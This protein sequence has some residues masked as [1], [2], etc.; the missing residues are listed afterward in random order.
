MRASLQH[1][2]FNESDLMF[3]HAVVLPPPGRDYTT[4][5]RRALDGR[6]E[7]VAASLDSFASRAEPLAQAAGMIVSTLRAGGRV[8][9]AGNGGSAAEAQHFAG[10]LVGRFLMERRPYAAISLTV[11]SSILTAI[12]NDYGFDDVFARQVHALGGPGD[13]LVAFSTSGKSPNL[14]RAADA[15]RECSMRTIAITGDLPSPLEQLADVTVRCPSTHT[16]ATQEL[17]MMVTHILCEIVEAEM[18][19][20]DRANE[21][22]EERESVS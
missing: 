3:S 10:E 17:Q 21:L 19:A 4:L 13:V 6:R 16:P 8:L 7:H 5:V 18:V 1:P 14:L 9:V 2:T 22:G 20:V 11:D 12:G 15:A